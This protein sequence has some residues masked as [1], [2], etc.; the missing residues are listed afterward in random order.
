M[1]LDLK[2]FLHFFPSKCLHTCKYNS[3]FA[4]SLLS[5]IVERIIQKTKKQKRNHAGG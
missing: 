5:E 1:Y 4:L 2:E 3:A